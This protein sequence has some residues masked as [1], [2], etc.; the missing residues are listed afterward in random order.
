VAA[1]RIPLTGPEEQ[2]LAMEVSQIGDVD[3][4]DVIQDMELNATLSNA[5]AA[6]AELKSQLA[7]AQ[8]QLVLDWARQLL[9]QRGNAFG[10]TLVASDRDCGEAA[11]ARQ[12]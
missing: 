11:V 4:W 5:Q 3:Q 6:R 2:L 12:P 9:E 1:S 7:P 10:A 8:F